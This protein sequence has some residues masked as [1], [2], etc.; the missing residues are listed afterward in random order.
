MKVTTY[1]ATVVQCQGDLA[2]LFVLFCSGFMLVSFE[3]LIAPLVC[4]SNVGRS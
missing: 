2:V 3:T 4:A 1:G